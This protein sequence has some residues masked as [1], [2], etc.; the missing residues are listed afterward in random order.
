MGFIQMAVR[1]LSLFLVSIASL[2]LT[3]AVFELGLRVSYR[4]IKAPDHTLVHQASSIPG[5]VYEM[6]PNRELRLTDGT[7][8]KTNQYGMRDSE[9]SLQR[10]ESPCRIAALGDSYTFGLKVLAEQAYPKVLERRLRQSAA[11]KDCPFEVLNFGT[12]GYSSWDEALML[13]YRVVDFDPHVVI[14]GYVLND[15]EVD[16]IQPLHAYFLRRPWWQ[17]YYLRRLVGKAEAIWDERH[18]GGG[19]YY[20]YLHAQG[21]RKWQSVVDAF[22]NIRDVTSPRGIKVLVVIFPEVTE[23]FKGKPWSDYPYTAIHQQVSDLAVRN[24]FRVVDLLEAFSA[25]P[26]R[27]LTFSGAD[28]HPNVAG[29]EVA[30][31]AIEKELL[32]EPSYFFDLKPHSPSN[33]LRIASR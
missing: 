16:P 5:L 1:R 31:R 8:I 17:P 15:P 23:S 32:A 25:Y 29:H 2:F 20:V 7:L 14:L 10:T 19:D 4:L 11:G 28:D 30:A 26:S 18:F 6:A 21:H 27:D 33:G 24:G 22:S 12:S 3:L 13:R 9:P